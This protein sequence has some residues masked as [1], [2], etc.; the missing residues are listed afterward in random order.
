MKKSICT[1]FLIAFLAHT[2]V[3][4]S[5][6]TLKCKTDTGEAT[7]DLVLNIENRTM[8]WGVSEYEIVHFDDN[9]VTSLELDTSKGG[10]EIFVISRITGKYTRGAVYRPAEIASDS[11]RGDIKYKT[12]DYM[13]AHTFAGE[14]KSQLF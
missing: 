9:F 1:F 10:G 5:P 2:N 7:V 8:H 13:V 12:A 4:A 11:T 3:L 14:C 6:V